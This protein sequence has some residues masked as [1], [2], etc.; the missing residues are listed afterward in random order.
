MQADPVHLQAQ[1][2]ALVLVPGT[3]LDIDAAEASALIGTL[4]DHFAAV[5]LQFLA[6]HPTRW[7]HVVGYMVA[8]YRREWQGSVFSAFIE[9]L[10]VLAGLGIGL[11]VLV[12]GAVAFVLSRRQT[13]I[14]SAQAT[15]LVDQRPSGVSRPTR[16]P[17][18]CMSPRRPVPPT[19][20]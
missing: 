20:G 2:A 1:R 9:P 4:N 5:G 13:P 3:Q 7:R 6:P 12:G 14:Y 17:S 19:H 18:R 11:G 15:V 16:L 10:V 8:V